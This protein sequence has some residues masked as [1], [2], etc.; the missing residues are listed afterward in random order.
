M[1]IYTYTDFIQPIEELAS[2]LNALNRH[3]HRTVRK[4]EK[5]KRRRIPIKQRK[6]LCEAFINSSFFELKD[7]SNTIHDIVNYIQQAEIFL[8]D[9]QLVRL[10]DI[11]GDESWQDFLAL[12]CFW[13]DNEDCQ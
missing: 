10:K 5:E 12:D 3:W 6:A 13:N 8:P 1:N 2:K 7:Y 4:W 9:N 11:I